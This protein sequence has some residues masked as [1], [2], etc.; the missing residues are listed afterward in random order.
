MKL[1]IGMA[2]YDDWVG[3]YFTVEALRMYQDLT[4]TEILVVDN[5]GDKGMQDWI[6]AWHG[7]V[8][9]YE[10]NTTPGTSQS[11]NSVFEKAKGEWVVCMDS[12]ILLAPGSVAALKDWVGKNPKCTGLLQGPMLYDDVRMCTTHMEPVWRDDMWGIW[13]QSR[14]SDSLPQEPWEI[15]M[16]GL[17]LF[18]CRHDAWLGFNPKFRGFGGEEGYIH[19]KYRQARRKTL[20]LPFMQWCHKFAA[21]GAGARYNVNIRDRIRNYFIGFDELGMDPTPI[22]NH[23]GKRLCDVV[24]EQWLKE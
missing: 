10:L 18:G 21:I 20:C 14:K 1:T 9:R 16:H 4:D 6:K 12:H 11:R 2:V 19:E 23:F 24:R 22:V 13:A 17:G 15:P 7:G 3:V 5:K 8:V